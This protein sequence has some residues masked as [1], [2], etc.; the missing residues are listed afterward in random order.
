MWGGKGKRK[1]Y[2][3]RKRIEIHYVYMCK[4]NIMEPTKHSIKKGRRGRE[5]W[6]YNAGQGLDLFKV[7]CTHVWNYHNEPSTYYY[8]I[9]VQNIKKY[10]M[11]DTLTFEHIGFNLRLWIMSK[12]KDL[13]PL[14]FHTAKK[15]FRYKCSLIAFLMLYEAQRV[16]RQD[17]I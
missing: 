14:S 13:T 17:V 12:C 3:G 16:K 8:C 9:L 6:E 2:W 5:E 7:H 4:D 11:T 15:K 1:G 10:K